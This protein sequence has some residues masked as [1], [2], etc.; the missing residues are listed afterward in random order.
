VS[1]EERRAFWQAVGLSLTAHTIMLRDVAIIDDQI[2]AAL[3]TAID[4]AT[5]GD[6]SEADDSLALVAAFDE[7]VD[8]L[9]PAAAVGAMR[10]ARSRHDVAASSQRILLR[11]GLLTL[12]NAEI[13]ARGALL[14]LADNNVFTLLAVWSQGVPLQPTNLSHFLTGTIAPLARAAVALQHSFAVIDRSPLGSS[15]LAGPGLPVDRDETA[16]LIGSQGPIE[17]TFDALSAVDHLTA[18]A[19]T[20]T[21]I[22]APVRRLLDEFMTWSRTDPQAIRFADQDLASEDPNLPHFRPPQLVD[23][24]TI[25]ARQVEEDSGTIARLSLDLPYGPIGQRADLPVNLALASLRRSAALTQSFAGFLVDGI[26][27]NRAWL[28]RGAGRNHITSGDLSDFLMAEESL[29]PASARN[30]ASMTAARA[31][32]EGLEASAITPA[33]IDAVALLVIGRELGVEIER[34]GAYLA[35][36]RFIEKRTVL[37]GPAPSSIREYLASARQ[38]LSLDRHWLE[39]RQRRIALATENLDIRFHEILDAAS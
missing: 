26:E 11:D 13:A 33:M 24:L 9:V 39:E 18:T 19:D 1:D 7:R 16:D 31:L 36:R 25:D 37:G 28:A 35:P 6:P 32:R 4:G 17:S 38:R 20:I 34:L 3:L 23:R 12:G 27:I 15:A 14:D 5:R 29:D 2:G 21:A 8:N 22:V 30:I 10:I